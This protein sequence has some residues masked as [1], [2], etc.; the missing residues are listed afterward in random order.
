MAVERR[1]GVCRRGRFAQCRPCVD[2]RD[3]R[4]GCQEFVEGDCASQLLGPIRH[5]LGIYVPLRRGDHHVEGAAALIGRLLHSGEVRSP[6]VRTGLI[7]GHATDRL[8]QIVDLIVVPEG[9]SVLAKDEHRIGTCDRFLELGFRCARKG[10]IRPWLLCE[11]LVDPRRT[12][13]WQ[14]PRWH[15]RL[16]RRCRRS[17]VLDD[18][19][20]AASNNHR[21]RKYRQGDVAIPL[22]KAP[23]IEW[24][25]RRR[26][27]P[28]AVVSHS[29]PPPNAFSWRS[30]KK[31]R[32]D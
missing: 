25:F 3:L 2:Q 26:H 27:C 9:P 8:R 14:A 22:E 13:F 11:T 24:G 29:R 23:S 10:G 1:V 18:E 30:E 7:Q 5:L 4:M 32:S 19:S 17:L 28:Q 31:R 6:G 12:R 21:D 16:A 20:H 15:G